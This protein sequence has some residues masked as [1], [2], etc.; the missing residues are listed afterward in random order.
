MSGNLRGGFRVAGPISP[1]VIEEYGKS[2][3]ITMEEAW[4]EDGALMTSDGFVRLIDPALLLP[5][6]DAI[7][8][9]HPG[10]LPVFATAWGDLIVQWERTYVLVLYRYGFFVPFSRRVSDVIFDDME[11]SATQQADLRR[12]F[13][14]DAVA[15]LGLPEIDECFGFKL[16]LA[17]GGPE[18]VDNVARRKLKEHL[19]F[20]VQ[21]SGAPRD[22][23][24]LDPPAA[25]EGTAR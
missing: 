23:D 6:M 5:V 17:M 20:L 12:L 22:L 18:S 24:E 16:P 25:E 4:T 14:D 19:A 11:D 8:P 7:L 3:P 9:S 15:A 2:V 10:A 21:T 1:E 13:Y